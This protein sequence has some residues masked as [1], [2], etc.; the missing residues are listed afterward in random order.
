MSNAPSTPLR[1]LFLGALFALGFGAVAAL[2]R[3]WLGAPEGDEVAPKLAYLEAHPGEFDVV[4]LG[5]S[6]VFRHVVPH[7]FDAELAGAGKPVRSFNLG[8]PG[9]LG[10]E[11]DFA[12]RRLLAVLADQ[13]SER[14]GSRPVVFFEPSAPRGSLLPALATTERTVAWHDFTGTRTALRLVLDEDRSWGQRLGFARDHLRAFLWNQTNYAQG[15]RL[16]ERLAP[17]LVR[18]VQARA[19]LADAA[20]YQALEDSADP[21]VLRRHA[22]FREGGDDFQVAVEQLRAVYR[23]PTPSLPSAA[24]SVDLARR[25][26][27][28]AEAAGVQL[29]SLVAPTLRPMSYARAIAPLLPGAYFYN[30]PAA[31]P[32][33]FEAANH[34]D[35]NHL[36]RSAAEAFTRSFATDFARSWPGL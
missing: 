5:S 36:T 15:P 19:Y 7:V 6:A 13:A 8:S 21:D 32:A 27:T 17:G 22:S 1:G 25:Q 4:F 33:F 23:R 26:V 10:L 35:K 14:P 20:G 30:S 2:Q 31:S 18:P 11:T 34:F 12:L 9:M 24:V 16:L 28:A 3:A 29:F